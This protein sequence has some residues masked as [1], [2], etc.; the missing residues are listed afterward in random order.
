MPIIPLTNLPG[1]TNEGDKV[2]FNVTDAGTNATL[3]KVFY[4]QGN[5]KNLEC[6]GAFT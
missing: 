3:I 6:T 2:V 5:A 4:G 1:Q